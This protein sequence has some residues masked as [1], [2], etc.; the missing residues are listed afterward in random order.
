MRGPI[1]GLLLA[2]SLAVSVLGA[3]VGSASGAV[4]EA[5]TKAFQAIYGAPPE[6]SGKVAIGGGLGRNFGFGEN[7]LFRACAGCTPA[8]GKNLAITLGTAK[9]EA[10]DSYV[11]GTLMSDKSGV[12]NPLSF[13]VQFADFQNNTVEGVGAVQSWSDTY[14]R[15]W[16]A[17]ICSDEA[18]TACKVEARAGAAVGEVRIENVSFEFN[19]G[20]AQIVVQGTVWGKWKSAAVPCISLNLP[21]AAQ[22]TDTLVETQGAEVGKEITAI[23]GEACL[24][25][26]NNDYYEGH[27]VVVNVKNTA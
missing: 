17:E 16:I 20:G 12:N 7:M 2:A 13:A 24:V 26:A 9:V 22:K 23:S 18:G 4:I 25:S 3:S 8:V 21:P 15:P 5:E 27:H 1:R 11:G 14:D 19:V 10:K 6:T